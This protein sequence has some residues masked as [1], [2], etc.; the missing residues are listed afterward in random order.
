MHQ[1][2]DMGHGTPK[3]SLDLNSLVFFCASGN[4][5]EG[6][7]CTDILGLSYLFTDS[8]SQI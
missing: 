8:S 7:Q 6:A 2:R 5:S 4:A 3:P 1:W